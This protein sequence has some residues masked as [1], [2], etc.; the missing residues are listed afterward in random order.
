MS[1]FLDENGLLYLWEK[2]KAMLSDKVDRVEGKVLS[3]NDYTDEEKRKLDGLEKYTLPV[4]G[5]ETLGGIMVGAGLAISNGVLS[6]T[7]GG[8][9]DEVEWE[10]ILNRPDLAL[11]SDLTG[12]YRFRGSVDNFAALPEKG[13]E[14]GDVWDVKSN[15]MNY[16]WT[17]EDWDALG[18]VFELESISNAEINAILDGV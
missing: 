7:G 14:K 13:N 6:T 15:G 2:I 4:A 1:K 10:N 18:Q 17:G 8:R 5:T 3:S 16:A 12:L 11:K 9:A